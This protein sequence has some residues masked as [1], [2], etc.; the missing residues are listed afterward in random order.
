MAEAEPGSAS[1]ALTPVQLAFHTLGR[2][3]P[4]V[5]AYACLRMDLD[6]PVDADLLGRA[7]VL[8]ERRHP[9]LR[10]RIRGLAGEP[11]QQVLPASGSPSWPS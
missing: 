8:L 7:L 3:H 6:R 11:R 4:D 10:V 2:L 9:M 5:A 1:F